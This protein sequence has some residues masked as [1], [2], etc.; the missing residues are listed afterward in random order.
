M[1]FQDKVKLNKE[2]YKSVK[3][4]NKTLNI[5]VKTRSNIKNIYTYSYVKKTKHDRSVDSSSVQC[6]VS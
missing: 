6:L 2:I 3:E 1:T 5:E 4:R